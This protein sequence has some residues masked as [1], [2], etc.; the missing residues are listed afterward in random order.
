MRNMSITRENYYQTLGINRD[1]TQK[2]I[3]KA[4]RRLARKFHPDLNPGDKSAEDRFKNINEA[5]EILS[6]IEKRQKYDRFGDQWQYAEQFA[7]SEQTRTRQSTGKA[8]TAFEFGDLSGI[9]GDL[10]SNVSSKSGGGHYPHRD[11]DIEHSVDVT[12]EEAY[13]GCKR[14]VQLR[15]GKL[16]AAC[17]GTGKIGNRMCTICNGSGE[18]VDVKRLEAKIPPGVKDGSRIRMAGQ[19]KTG[20]GNGAKGDL[21]F[22]VKV[23]PHH[24]FERREDDLYAE[25]EVPLMTAMLGGEVQ[26]AGL[27]SK[28]ILRIPTET[29]NGKTFRLMKKG[30]PRMND[31]GYGDMFAKVKVV[32]PT[33]LT[34]LEKQLFRQLQSSKS[35]EAR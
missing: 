17:G 16:C 7:K 13:H 35:G 30:M 25:V 6:D 20:Y 19:G 32:L 5:Y 3:K 28:L 18:V 2:D 10:F 11:L 9:F 27:S 14:T 26:V 31:S 34:E 12:L 22:V 33:H 15:G 8:R 24:I 4:Y 1:A 23:L 29:Q 21:Y